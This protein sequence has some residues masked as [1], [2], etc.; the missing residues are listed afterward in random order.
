MSKSVDTRFL[1]RQSGG[2]K[3][4]PKDM[5]TD[6]LFNTLKMIWNNSSPV[7]LRLAP[8]KLYS[9][10]KT[11]YT[12]DYM[13]RAVQAMCWELNGRELNQYQTE[14]LQFMAQKMA[15]IGR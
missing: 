11:I 10:D 8:V 4:A 5:A 13:T 6:H 2:Q 12:L 3:I 7:S 1:W 14:S 9:F 15:R